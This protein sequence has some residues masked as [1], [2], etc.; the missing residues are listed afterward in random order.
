MLLFEFI[1]LK[2]PVPSDSQKEENGGKEMSRKAFRPERGRVLLV[3]TWGD[4]KDLLHFHGLLRKDA[5][6]MLPAQAE[7]NA[8]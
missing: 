5:L 8:R 4:C 2:N 7:A 6:G 3:W 1:I